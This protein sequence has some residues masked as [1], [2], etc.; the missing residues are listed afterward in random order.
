MTSSLPTVA[1]VDDDDDLRAAT[2]QLLGLAGY[3]VLGFADGFGA[4]QAIGEDFDG[5]V[6]SDVRM[7]HMSG[8]E[9]FHLLQQRDRDLP[10][11]LISGH[12]DVQM[13]V[14]ALKAGAWDF[15]EKP[16]APDALLAAASRATKARK[17]ALENRALR[18]AVSGAGD[19][20]FLGETPMIQRL[21]A[22]IPVLSQSD[23]DLVIEGQTGTG[24]ELFARCVHRSSARAKHRFVTVDCALIP[25]A[26]VE[27]EMFARGGIVASSHRGTLFLDN[28]DQASGDLQRR[29]AQ[30][31]EKRA[32]ALDMRDPEPIDTRIIASMAE[33]GRDAVTDAL[34]HR[35]AGVPLRIPP[36]S[37][38]RADI[39]LL[40]TH[41]LQKAAE[42]LGRPRR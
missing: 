41:F 35:I 42:R 20:A 24:K 21:R 40:F 10:V 34:Y 17:L 1:L 32:I 22:M 15:I 27:R 3:R 14:D 7:S 12:A 29:L 30:F 13:A 39:R 25:A 23:I 2:A 36:L 18:R 37:E 16:F 4:A 11:L 8:V 9:L 28:L 6:I 31:A 19:Q 38:R 5:I 33:G 26:I